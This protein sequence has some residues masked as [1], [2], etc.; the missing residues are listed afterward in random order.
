MHASVH[1]DGW[2]ELPNPQGFANHKGIHIHFEGA[3]VRANVSEADVA[4]QMKPYEDCAC[5][6]EARTA[7]Y[8]AT[9][10]SFVVPFYTLE[11]AG[12]FAT[13]TPE[14][15]AFAAQ[16]VAAGADQLRD[17]IIDAWHAS[18]DAK[19]GYPQVAVKDVEAGSADALGALQG[20]D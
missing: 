3:F 20:E 4:A 1:Y 10:N 15:R 2:G 12:A 19:V 17:M 14:G 6:I 18:A 8:L 9:T 5:S 7:S 11:K 13:A 16:R